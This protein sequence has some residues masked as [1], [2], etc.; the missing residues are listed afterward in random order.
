MYLYAKY[1]NEVK[2]HFLI[3]KRESIGSNDSKILI[4]Y[5]NN[6]VVENQSLNKKRQI[7]IAFDDMIA[8]MVS[9]KKLNPIV[10]DMLSNKKLNPAVIELFIRGREIN[11]SLVF[12][13]QSYFTA[14]KDIRLNSIALF[15]YENSR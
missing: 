10:I 9:N 3:N 4:E 6:M 1:L 14:P 15:S 2:Y 5:S 11:I 13:M 8:D 12:I 7:L